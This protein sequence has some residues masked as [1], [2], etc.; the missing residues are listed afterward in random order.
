MLSRRERVPI[1]SAEE[2]TTRWI[3]VV[4]DDWCKG[5]G[6]CYTFCPRQVLDKSK[7]FNTKGYYPPVVIAAD[8]CVGCRLCE[9]LCPDFAIYVREEPKETTSGE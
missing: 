9:A 7:E 5:C 6:F 8:R 1:T 2:S 3:V 4:N